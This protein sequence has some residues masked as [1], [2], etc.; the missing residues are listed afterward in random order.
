MKGNVVMVVLSVL[1]LIMNMMEALEA[2]VVDVASLNRSSFPA[3][4][5]FGTA[6]SAYQYEGAA[7]EDGRVPSIWD[8][9]THTHPDAIPVRI[10]IC[11][12]NNFPRFH[13]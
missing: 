11:R 1:A 3:G 4:F 9:F 6:S 7:N 10:N 12:N 2:T 8:T 5:V 13:S